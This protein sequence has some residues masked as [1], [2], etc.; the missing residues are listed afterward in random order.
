LLARNLKRQNKEITM[1]IQ[2]AIN[3]VPAN[4]PSVWS[5]FGNWARRTLEQMP[6]N[7]EDVDPA[8]LRLMPPF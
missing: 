7:F 1:S 6:T 2:T 8:L 5:R 3:S 4:R